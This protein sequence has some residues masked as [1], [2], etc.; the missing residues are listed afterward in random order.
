MD[1][2]IGV[3]GIVI[4]S[5]TSIEHV[6]QLLTDHNHIISGRMGIPH[7][8]GRAVNVISLVVD[9]TNDD[10]GSLAGKLGKVSGVSVKTAISKKTFSPLNKNLDPQ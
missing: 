7:L 1:H 3:I 10:I 8:N 5:P 4:E 6:N 2:R 9:G